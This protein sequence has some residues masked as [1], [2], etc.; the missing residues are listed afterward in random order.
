MFDIVKKYPKVDLELVKKFSAVKESASI[1][2]CLKKNGSLNH[3]LRPVW[4][5]SRFCGVAF[6]VSARAGD[7]LIL[8]KAISLLK[9]GDA[10]VV[11][12]D[13]FLES[14]GMW[15]GIMSSAAQ[16][17]GAVALVT[18]GSVRD[19]MHMKEIGFPVFSC[20]I[21]VKRSTKAVGGTINH[22]ITICGVQVNPGD[23]VF[24]DNDA[25][26]VVPREEAAQVYEAA[27]ARE[28]YEENSL[29]NVQKDGTFTFGAEFR[30]NF[31]ALGL[32]EEED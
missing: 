16:K 19:T 4:P 30:R 31:A 21:N 22:P 12:C 28:A 27:A 14:G 10:I 8:H 29:I 7:N 6:T 25:V 2:E 24:G 1:N 26:V 18:D 9:P 13:G 3:D 15:G 17:M 32:S 11:T 20:G 5:G 23:L